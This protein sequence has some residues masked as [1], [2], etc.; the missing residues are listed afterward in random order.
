[1]FGLGFLN[2]VFLLA[3][4]AVLLPLVIH[5]L[6]RR[7]ARRIDFSSLKFIE[8]VQRRKM[9]KLNLR[10]LIVLLLRML[11]VFFIVLAFARPTVKSFAGFLLPT[12]APSSVVICID[13]SYSMGVEREK[14]SAFTKAKELAAR[15]VDESGRKDRIN[16]VVFSNRSEA[17]FRAGSRNKE[18]VKK[19]IER[20]EVSEG[21]TN[22]ASALREAMRLVR[23]SGLQRGEI[24]LVSDFRALPDSSFMPAKM[25]GVQLFLVPVYEE[26]VENVSIDKVSVPRKLI[27]PGESIKLGVTVTNHSRSDEARFQMEIVVDGKRKA[28]KQVVLSP[29]SSVTLTFPLSLASRGIYKG[30]VRK[31][32]DRLPVDDERFFL[33]EV[34]KSIP[35]LVVRGS[36]GGAGD[37]EE[38]YFYVAKALNPRSG[39]QGEFQ[40]KI[41]SEKSLTLADLPAKGV[42]VWVSPGV[43][44]P[45][46][47]ESLV[48]YVRR[49]GAMAVFLAGGHGGVLANKRLA[50]FLG[51]KRFLDTEV[52]G[53]VHIGT[54]KGEHPI[55]ELFSEEELELLSR[56]LIERYV[57]VL[58]VEPDSVLAYLEGGD[59]FA[60]ECRRGEGRVVVF[61]ASPD[62]AGGDLPLSPMF[63]PLVHTTASYLADASRADAG[64][65]NHVGE[66][67]VFD[68]GE[69]APAPQSDLTVKA[70][71]AYVG[72]A[73]PFDKP[74]GGRGALFDFP[75]AK[76]FYEVYSDSLLLAT[77]VVNVNTIESDLNPM[78]IFRVTGEAKVVAPGSDFDRNLE[79]ARK[80]R[81][82]YAL[83]ILLAIGALAAESLLGRKA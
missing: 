52:P 58:G 39:G 15:V 71:G 14:G 40:V 41:A 2:S 57:S 50:S 13:A 12:G 59:P 23:E 81:E 75:Q 17:L 3:L 55:F 67:L 28:E 7:R 53:G 49:G 4:G 25:E 29:S 21:T 19:A 26:A 20:L 6:N 68:L 60:W 69:L 43:V 63:L 11:A 56:V 77:A 70:E 72:R 38:G 64:R 44:P 82:I 83:F 10:R 66:G 65:E 18:A 37:R 31:S 35:V 45:E 80:G 54:F 47:L 8:E 61:A 27:R 24:Y 36:E 1:L 48:R 42:V 30:V 34:S 76:G 5:L 22:T 33:L 73:V 51:V 79:V 9:R 32:K 46:R 74:G 62:L 78:D 16:V